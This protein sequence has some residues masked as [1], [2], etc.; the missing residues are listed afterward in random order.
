MSFNDLCPESLELRAVPYGK[1]QSLQACW[2]I[3]VRGRMG[4][5]LLKINGQ[6]QRCRTHRQARK[7]MKLI[8]RNRL[9]AVPGGVRAQ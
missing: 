2:E 3:E 6:L 5:H 1:T 7:R 4:W 8:K 9:Y